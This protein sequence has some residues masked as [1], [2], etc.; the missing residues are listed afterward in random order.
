M[1]HIESLYQKAVVQWFRYQYP[2]WKDLLMSYPIG[3]NMSKEQ[4]SFN[5]QMGAKAGMPDLMLLLPVLIDDEWSHG[6]FIEMKIEDGRLSDSQKYMHAQLGAQGY[7]VITCYGLDEAKEQLSRYVAFHG[8]S[9]LA[10]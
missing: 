8:I 10:S 4:A 9:S 3:I 6:L 7:T 2:K 5:K 1:K